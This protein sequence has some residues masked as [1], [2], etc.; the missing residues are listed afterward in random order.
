LIRIRRFGFSEFEIYLTPVCFGFRAS[1]FGFCFDGEE[2]R[3]DKNFLGDLPAVQRRVLLP[4]AGASAQED[5]APLPLLQSPVFRRRERQNRRVIQM[6]LDF[7]FQPKSAK[8]RIS[9]K[10]FG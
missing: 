1:N 7:R 5:Q 3:R 4:L 10:L 9:P 8:G 6:I 2:K